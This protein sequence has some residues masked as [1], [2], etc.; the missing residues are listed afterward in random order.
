VTLQIGAVVTNIDCKAQDESV[1]GDEIVRN[2]KSL[3]ATYAQ[4]NGLSMF[5]KFN[6]PLRMKKSY[7]SKKL[8]VVSDNVRDTYETSTDYVSY[9]VAGYQGVYPDK[10][11]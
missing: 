7:Y 1:Q 8:D 11:R 2:F 4:D 3:V 5:A 10:I 6:M 9:G